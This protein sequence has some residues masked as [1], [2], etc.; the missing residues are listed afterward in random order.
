MT[1]RRLLSWIG[2]PMLGASMTAFACGGGWLRSPAEIVMACGK[3]QPR[4][5]LT[6]RRPST[7]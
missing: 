1:T 4:A 5:G 7:A 6:L 3:W 2:V